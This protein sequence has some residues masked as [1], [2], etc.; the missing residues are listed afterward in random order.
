MLGS[1]TGFGGS[2]FLDSVGDAMIPH[3]IAGSSILMSA[4]VEPSDLPSGCSLSIGR[5]AVSVLRIY[6]HKLLHAPP[7]VLPRVVHCF[8]PPPATA[9]FRY[10][11][12]DGKKNWHL[13]C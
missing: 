4:V 6:S 10:A 9:I 7:S 3:H 8:R 2:K 5:P 13:M 11:V 12:R 1:V